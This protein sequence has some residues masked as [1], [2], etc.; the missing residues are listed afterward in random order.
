MQSEAKTP[1]P[2]VDF[3]AVDLVAG[4]FGRRLAWR[5]FW[6]SSVIAFVQRRKGPVLSPPGADAFVLQFDDFLRR[7]VHQYNQIL[8]RPIFAREHGQEREPTAGGASGGVGADGAARDDDFFDLL[9]ATL[10][11]G[12]APTWIGANDVGSLAVIVVGQGAG[13]GLG[14]ILP[15]NQL[16]SVEIDNGF[17]SGIAGPIVED[18]ERLARQHVSG[19]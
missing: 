10:R 18:G 17:A 19:T 7:Q 3:V 2:P 5:T 4:T 9:N 6:P 14:H 13:L 16:F 8:D 1:M 15:G 11:H 12:L